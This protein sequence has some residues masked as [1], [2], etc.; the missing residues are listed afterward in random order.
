MAMHKTGIV[1]AVVLTCTFIASASAIVANYYLQQQ[2]PNPTTAPT[3]NQNPFS[4][5]TSKPRQPAYGGTI[6]LSNLYNTELTYVY[7]VEPTALEKVMITL[8]SA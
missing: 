4:P 7:V 2:T 3:N 8:V 5:S 6:P 1:I